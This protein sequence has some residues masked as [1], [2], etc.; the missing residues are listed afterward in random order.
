VT[1]RLM[2]QVLMIAGCLV[3]GCGGSNASTPA[4]VDAQSAPSDGG[5]TDLTFD[6]G[7]L[8]ECRGP[9]PVDAGTCAPHFQPAGASRC[10][11]TPTS[12]DCT[13]TI[14]T[15]GG[16]QV[17]WQVPLGSPPA[18]GW[19]AVIVFQGSLYGPDM[20]WSGGAGLPFGGL[21]QIRLQALLLDNGLA[22]IAPTTSN[23]TYWLTNFPGYDTSADNTF[24]LALLADIAAGT[25]FG[26]VDPKR[27][28]ATGVSSGGFMTSRMA[29]SYRGHFAALAI[30]SGGYA[31]CPALCTSP[32]PAL[33]AD[34]PPTLFLHGGKDP[35]VA[36]SYARSYYAELIGQGIEGE[37]II[38]P[39]AGHQWLD[40][41]PEAIT[42]WF[43]SH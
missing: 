26:P 31:T 36:P 25:T 9:R 18:N 39:G 17:Y 35:L 11:V 29:V 2:Q 3:A 5:C 43:L 8:S 27:L 24:I 30:E 40:V 19:P 4:S 1:T 38:D 22:V 6:G 42:C 13:P 16:R 41:A 32:L 7:T 23:G 10:T 34:H 21:N 15:V 14:S 12:V 28:Y 20:S 37:I 33:P